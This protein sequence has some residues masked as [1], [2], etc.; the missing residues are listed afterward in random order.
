MFSDCTVLVNE[1]EG[2]ILGAFFRNNFIMCRKLRSPLTM[3]SQFMVDGFTTSTCSVSI[4]DICVCVG[5][6]EREKEREREREKGG[7]QA[8]GSFYYTVIIHIQHL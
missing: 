8:S 7:Q 5:V 6:S 3:G 2:P 4:Q 1:E